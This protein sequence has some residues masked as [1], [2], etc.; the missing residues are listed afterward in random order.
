MEDYVWFAAEGRV[1]GNVEIRVGDV[2]RG[3][4]EYDVVIRLVAIKSKVLGE[5]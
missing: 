1:F 5:Y 2:F 4:S 3:L